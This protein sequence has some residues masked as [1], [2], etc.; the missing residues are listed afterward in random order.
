MRLDGSPAAVSAILSARLNIDDPA[1]V[2]VALSGGGDSV[3]LLGMAAAWAKASGRPLIAFT[4]DHGLHPDSGAWTLAAGRAAARA[5]VRWRAL[6]WE[7]EKSVVGLPAAAR[8]ARHRLIADAARA[9]GARVVLFGHT[10]DDIQEAGR[11]RAAGS[12]VPDPREWSASPAWPEGRGVFL[13]RPMLSLR[14]AALR[15]WLTARNEV[16]LEDPANDDLRFARARARQEA[17]QPAE[18]HEGP[19]YDAV[20]ISTNA[21]RLALDVADGEAGLIAR[22]AVCAAGGVRPPRGLRTVKLADRIAARETFVATLAGAVIESDGRQVAFARD[23][24]ERAR[25]GLAPLGLETGEAGVWDG[26]FAVRA[27]ERGTVAPL[28]GLQARLSRPELAALKAIAPRARSALP[29]WIGA[30]GAVALPQPFG[31]APL[32]ADCLVGARFAAA[33]GRVGRERD[34]GARPIQDGAAG[35]RPLS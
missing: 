29:A 19:R 17:G 21:G 15:D 28:L 24:G 11:M 10:A 7:G 18:I 5:G 6:R 3:A 34:I 14:R 2:G 27:H 30:S 23:A 22:A 12:T 25:G 20:A 8:A 13:L 1:P 16:W 26:R 33:C 32:E 9:E 35:L 4:V 31:T